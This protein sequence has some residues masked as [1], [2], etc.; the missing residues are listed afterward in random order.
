MHYGKARREANKMDLKTNLAWHVIKIKSMGFMAVESS[1]FFSNEE[2]LNYPAHYSSSEFLVV[3]RGAID[4]LF[5]LRRSA[6]SSLVAYCRDIDVD[7]EEITDE[8][9]KR[10]KMTASQAHNRNVVS[11]KVFTTGKG[12][13]IFQIPKTK[14]ANRRRRLPSLFDSLKI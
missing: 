9:F 4:T 1:W 2:R 3:K 8:Q 11:M 14:S 12:D 5:K 6:W 10:W 13:S 7:V